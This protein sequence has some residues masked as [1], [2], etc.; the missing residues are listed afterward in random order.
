[1]EYLEDV[2]VPAV[3]GV[4][5]SDLQTWNGGIIYR[6]VTKAGDPKDGSLPDGVDVFDTL[7]GLE[8][9]TEGTAAGMTYGLC[10]DCKR[11]TPDDVATHYDNN[12][13]Q[14]PLTARPDHFQPLTFGNLREKVSAQMVEYQPQPSADEN[15]DNSE[16]F[17]YAYTL[18]TFLYRNLNASLRQFSHGNR[19]I[20]QRYQAFSAGLD[21][22]LQSMAP[23]EGVVYRGMTFQVNVNQYREGSVICFPSFTSASTDPRVARDFIGSGPTPKGTLFII[24]SLHGRPVSHKSDLPEEAEVLF[25]CTSIFRVDRHADPG[26][27]K[28]LEVALQCSLKDVFIIHLREI[29]LLAWDTLPQA[30]NSLERATYPQLVERCNAIY[31]EAR[32]RHL[33]PES[34]NPVAEHCDKP[35]ASLPLVKLMLFQAN[36]ADPENQEA[37]STALEACLRH[38]NKEIA[39]YLCHRL[40]DHGALNVPDA[41]NVAEIVCEVGAEV[42]GP[43]RQWAV[44]S[45]LARQD[46]FDVNKRF[47]GALKERTLAHQACAAG[48]LETLATLAGL[49]GFD[50]SA[51]DKEGDTCLHLASR[52]GHLEVVKYLAQ[53]EGFLSSVNEVNSNYFSAFAEA[54]YKGNLEVVRYL[55]Q[56]PR[57]KTK[58]NEEDEGD[59]DEE[60][61]EEEEEADPGID[62]NQLCGHLAATPFLLAVE[63]DR[64]DVVRFVGRLEGVDLER[65]NC[66]GDTPFSLACQYSD[67]EMVQALAG[68]EG[69]DIRRTDADG[70][71][72]FGLIAH[73]PERVEIARF[74]MSL[75]NADPSWTLPAKQDE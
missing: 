47:G 61:E 26:M 52:A 50:P 63:A 23:F 27:Q 10:P 3:F 22:E 67:L 7:K 74:L 44:L 15:Q 34:S 8:F 54:C 62:I 13:P 5:E 43:E 58:G 51:G 2:G 70:V 56:L 37:I 14:T 66:Y 53:Q 45:H 33:R 24:K 17:V 9:D 28:L 60:D 39:V 72:C 75:P 18:E 49:E 29:D 40:L 73:D 68:L 12:H 4:H 20:F 59:E 1:M 19:S 71:T 30:M 48:H 55:S 65:S 16:G 32:L 21:G 38:S 11:F 41:A 46:G 42:V 69:L 36:V 57:R 64:H 31:Y 35:G 25:R 6:T